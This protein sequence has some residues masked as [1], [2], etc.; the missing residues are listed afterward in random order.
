[1]L[2][3]DGNENENE[4]LPE[5]K[6]ILLGETHTGKTSLIS[7]LIYSTF[8]E[9]EAS[10]LVASNFSKVIEYKEFG[11]TRLRLQI[12]D[13]AGQ[14]R[15]RSINKIFYKDASIAILV[16]DITNERTFKEIENYWYNQ[17]KLYGDKNVRK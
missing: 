12:W 5:C 7:R 9:N 13:T 17:V 2:N 1:M 3:D 8:V 15:F 4:N 6:I 14:E 10:T 16:Y 11:G